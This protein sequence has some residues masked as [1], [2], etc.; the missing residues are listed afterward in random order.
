M[1]A[2][3]TIIAIMAAVLVVAYIIQPFITE[4]RIG[5]RRSGERLAA[6]DLRRRADVLTERN[7]IYRAIRE[8]DFEYKTGKVADEDYAE[9]RHKLVAQ[10]VEAL[11]QLDALTPPEDDVIEQAILRAREGRPVRYAD[12]TGA[13]SGSEFCPQC[14]TRAEPGD[15]FCVSC[16]A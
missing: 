10:G 3:P 4:G 7:R 12:V 1:E 9:Q 5:Q 16:G 6:S 2:L 15:R 14:G 13:S 8:L 11:Q